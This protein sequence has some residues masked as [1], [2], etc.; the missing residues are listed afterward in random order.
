[1]DSCRSTAGE[2]R[3]AAPAAPSQRDVQVRGR[4]VRIA[5]QGDRGRHVVLLHGLPTHAGLWRRV[6]PA[7]AGVCRTVAI[8]LP[9]FGGSDP[10]DR[11]HDLAALADALDETLEALGVEQPVFVALDLGLL[12]ALQWLARHPQRVPGIV[13]MEGFFLPMQ[14]GWK[15]LPMASRMLMRLARWPWLAERA[16]VRDDDAVERFV[17][18]GVCRG[19]DEGDIARYAQPWRD[20]ARRRAVWLRGIHAGRLVPPSRSPGD[21]VERIDTAAAALAR[22]PMPKLLLTATPGTV[23]TPATVAAARQRLPGL[24]V[25]PVG[26]GRHLL[27]EDQPEAIARAVVDFVQGL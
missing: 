21:A 10:I 3:D 18:A 11:P 5:A 12:V 24:R 9:G 13:M 4:R 15:A 22:A 19:L 16:I 17:R 14:V 6:Q 27:P 7:L 2:S 8:D 1:M 23:V 26:R 20:P 25:V